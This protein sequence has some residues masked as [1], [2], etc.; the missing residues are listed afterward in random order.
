MMLLKRFVCDY[1]FLQQEE[2]SAG[3]VVRE[4]KKKLGGK[5]GQESWGG[6][7]KESMSR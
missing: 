5:G 6:S 4:E 3:S 7:W 2:G 1:G